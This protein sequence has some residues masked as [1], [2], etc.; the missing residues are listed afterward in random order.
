MQHLSQNNALRNKF[1]A[2][3][4]KSARVFHR[5]LER[6]GVIACDDIER[7]INRSRVAH[8]QA[9]SLNRLREYGLSV[10]I[11]EYEQGGFH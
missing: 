11:P 1:D 4:V 2:M 8:M 3:P 9:L 7:T 5:Q 6:A 10:S